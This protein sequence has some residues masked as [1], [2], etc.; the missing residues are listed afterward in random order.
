MEVKVYILGRY[1]LVVDLFSVF[2][3]L[4]VFDDFSCGGMLL[5][6]SLLLSLLSLSNHDYLILLQCII[7]IYLL[8]NWI[9]KYS[10]KPL[11][12]PP[13]ALAPISHCVF[14]V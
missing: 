8:Y 7:V 10:Y 5:C 3:V 1:S 4:K 14:T 6:G 13:L 2:L 9:V 11:R 12:W